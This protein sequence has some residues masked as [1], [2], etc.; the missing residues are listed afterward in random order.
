MVAAYV[1]V[2]EQNLSELSTFKGLIVHVTVSGWH[3]KEENSLRLGEFERYA[4]TLPN[5]FLRIVNRM[6]WAGVGTPVPDSG[7]RV[8]RWL[9]SEID[10]RRLG[11]RVIRTPFHSVHTFPG[12]RPGA[13]GTRHMAGAD[14]AD[15][16]ARLFSDGAKECCTTGKCK[17]CPTRCGAP[18]SPPMRTSLIAAR[19]L[20]AMLSFEIARQAGI[21]TPSPLAVYTARLLARKGAEQYAEAGDNV[22]HCRLSE[23]HGMYDRVSRKLSLTP[24]DRRRLANDSHALVM[25]GLDRHGLWTHSKS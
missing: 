10:R 21:G 12:S 11:N 8:E 22:G 13:L 23:V 20:D 3:S 25:N 7:A 6:D 2:P 1:R 17:T 5:V 24:T 14:Y 19:A 18:G 9:L 4:S 16:W 15:E